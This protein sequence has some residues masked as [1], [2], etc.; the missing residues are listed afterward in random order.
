MAKPRASTAK[1]TATMALATFHSPES[2]SQLLTRSSGV[3]GRWIWLRFLPNSP[4][5]A[6]LTNSSVRAVAALYTTARTD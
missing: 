5:N 4:F 1:K 2:S 3:A 6:D